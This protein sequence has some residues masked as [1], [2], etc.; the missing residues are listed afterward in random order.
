MALKLTN[1]MQALDN[2]KEQNGGILPSDLY[3]KTNQQL[4]EILYDLTGKFPASRTSKTLLVQRIEQ[5]TQGNSN[6]ENIEPNAGK[7]KNHYDSETQAPAKKS[8]RGCLTLL[9]PSQ[10]VEMQRVMKMGASALAAR[11]KC[12]QLFQIWHAM[13]VMANCPGRSSKENVAIKL[14]EFAERNLDFHNLC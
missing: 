4:S 12:T 13:G 11:Y 2:N 3:L 6:K 8:K 14:F 9:T 7:R 1:Y 10:V 5:Q